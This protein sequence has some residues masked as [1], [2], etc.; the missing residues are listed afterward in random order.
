MSGFVNPQDF[1]SIQ[2]GA[3]SSNTNMPDDTPM[4][5]LEQL[6][7]VDNFMNSADQN[8]LSAEPN[9]DDQLS[10]ELAAFADDSFIFPDEEK[11]KLKMEYSNS[12]NNDQF[13]Q[14]ESS[15]RAQ[16][17]IPSTISE[18]L[19]RPYSQ[20]QNSHVS[21]SSAQKPEL[22]SESSLPKVTVPRG[23]QN[24]L[25]AAGLSQT[26]I[27]ALA[28]LIAYHKPDIIQREN[29]SS[30]SSSGS[31]NGS[32]N[33]SESGA[34]VSSFEPLES[35]SSSHIVPMSSTVSPD[36]YSSEPKEYV[37]TDK[38][39]RNTAASARFRI[40]KKLKE[41][42]ME[43]KLKELTDLSRNLE[44]KIQQ[45]EMENRLLRNL[46]VEKGSQRDSEELER[47][48]K[49]ARISVDQEGFPKPN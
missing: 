15:D 38:R 23:A 27:E 40:K 37:E 2:Q 11:P 12:N 33:G 42:E 17:S 31:Q 21:A 4:A 41:Q 28:T 39:R 9:F 14:F 7:Y 47:L 19:Q 35:S 16:G 34:Q 30:E 1:N 24:T 29:S 26:Q 45:L 46:V 10:V 36:V 22:S 8:D 48:R 44:L 18:L 49:K 43:R 5:L 13:D 20:L 32:R 25:S 3:S 6:V